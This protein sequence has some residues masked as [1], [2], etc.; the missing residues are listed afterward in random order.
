MGL[1]FCRVALILLVFH[2]VKRSRLQD[3][4]I[5]PVYA[6]VFQCSTPTNMEERRLPV[7]LEVENVCETSAVSLCL[8]FSGSNYLI[9][10]IYP[11]DIEVIPAVM[12]D[13]WVFRAGTC[14]DGIL[15]QYSMEG[16]RKI[17]VG[18]TSVSTDAFY[19]P[20][21]FSTSIDCTLTTVPP[22][23]AVYAATSQYLPLEVRPMIDSQFQDDGEANPL[24][25]VS[26]D[27][28]LS[29]T[30][31]HA[32]MLARHGVRINKTMEL[33]LHSRAL[34]NYIR[35][36]NP[37]LVGREL[38][39]PQSYLAFYGSATAALVANATAS[40]TWISDVPSL[41]QAGI[42]TLQLMRTAAISVEEAQPFPDDLWPPASLVTVP[43]SGSGNVVSI[44][45]ESRTSISMRANQLAAKL[46]T[47]GRVTATEGQNYC[48][49]L[50]SGHWRFR[51]ITRSNESLSAV[52]CC[53]RGCFSLE[54]SSTM[55]AFAFTDTFKENCC[56]VCNLANL[57][58]DSVKPNLIAVR[59]MAEIHSPTD[60]NTTV[61]APIRVTI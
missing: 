42:D 37:F 50:Q 27:Q 4:P 15:Q 14:R 36:C 58:S 52:D 22:L 55:V 40:A 44:R 16:S 30:Y 25:T 3:T 61:T 12:E 18:C 34:I 49:S 39:L 26:T 59:N 56:Y 23:S 11:N 54:E 35:R 57:C 43:S 51:R 60:S 53:S 29:T 38:A 20:L 1:Y 24:T 6:E 17:I 45:T 8:E 32:V 19:I 31:T 33:F 28:L 5:T 21:P 7:V 2:A 46:N 48:D 47:T 41:T 10:T 13:C 9:R